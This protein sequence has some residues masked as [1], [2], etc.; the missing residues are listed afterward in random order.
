MGSD[1]EEPIKWINN[2]SASK[3]EQGLTHFQAE[4]VES[5]EKADNQVL[6]F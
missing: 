2:L 5:L 3:N 1:Y 6:S 4:K